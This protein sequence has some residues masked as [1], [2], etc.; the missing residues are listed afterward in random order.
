[1]LETEHR[2]RQP[3]ASVSEPPRSGAAARLSERVTEEAG[4]GDLTNAGA[5]THR[6]PAPWVVLEQDEVDPLAGVEDVVVGVDVA[7][8]VAVGVVD[9]GFVRA[10]ALEGG[11]PG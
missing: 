4:F 2:A 6:R 9:A 3:D 10:D 5:V 8:V 11:A 1:V 7:D